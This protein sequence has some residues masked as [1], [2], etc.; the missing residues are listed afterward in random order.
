MGAKVKYRKTYHALG[1]AHLEAQCDLERLKED[2][3]IW[4]DSRVWITYEPAFE[5]FRSEELSIRAT[6]IQDKDILMWN[7]LK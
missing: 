5:P 3:P 1:S 7:R 2:D 4:R 6:R